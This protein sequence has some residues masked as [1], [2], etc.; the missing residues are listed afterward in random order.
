MPLAEQA[1]KVISPQSSEFY[2]HAEKKKIDCPRRDPNSGQQILSIFVI[3]ARRCAT[4]P[5]VKIV[6]SVWEGCVIQKVVSRIVK[7]RC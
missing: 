7:C 1:T 3:G 5:P 2:K 6:G 4:G